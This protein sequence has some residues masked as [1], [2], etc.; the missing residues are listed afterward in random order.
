MESL[1]WKAIVT[2]AIVAGIGVLFAAIVGSAAWFA[3]H[4]VFGP[5]AE[6]RKQRRLAD[7]AKVYRL[8]EA[9]NDPFPC[10]RCFRE[11]PFWFM[12]FPDWKLLDDSG[13]AITP[14]PRD[15]STCRVCLGISKEYPEPYEPQEAFERRERK[16]R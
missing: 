1:D 3:N 9:K 6:V 7:A 13:A 14:V 8:N 5:W 4:V 2:A 12:V 15:P 16:Q 11:V 10:P